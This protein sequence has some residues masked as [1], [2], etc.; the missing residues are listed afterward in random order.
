MF[1]RTIV[2]GL[3]ACWV[4]AAGAAGS[5]VLIDAPPAADTLAFGASVW[6]LPQFPG[7]ARSDTLVLPGVDWY[8]RNGWFVSTDNGVGYNA[9]PTKDVQAGVR[10]WPQFGRSKGDAPAGLE[11]IGLRIQP[12]AFV[13]ALVAG[14]V[15]VQG[16]WAAGAGRKGKGSQLELGLTT[17]IPMDRT[18]IGFGLSR[19]WA[20]AAFR[21]DYFGVSAASAQASG[22]PATT[23]GGGGLDQA[24]SV[25]LEH[26]FDDRWRI[27]GQVVRSRFDHSVAVSPVVQSRWQSQATLTLWRAW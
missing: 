9:A 13:N 1:Q 27:S 25:S 22:L 4:S 19:T 26:R 15:L 17:G 18:L 23:L 14:V 5:L 3:A 24:A 10:L 12:Q 20:N 6:R 21:D 11:S 7:A 2:A 8:S 16:A